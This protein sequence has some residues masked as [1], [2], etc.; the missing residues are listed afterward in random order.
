[1][2][3]PSYLAS[4]R[5]SSANRSARS[6]TD[7]PQLDGEVGPGEARRGGIV[8]EVTPDATGLRLRLKGGVTATGSLFELGSYGLSCT[9]C[10]SSCT[11][12]GRRA[13]KSMI[14]AQVGVMRM[15]T[16]CW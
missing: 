5:V 15:S 12:P 6:A 2:G 13:S 9:R 3:R 14:L 11:Y 1:M 16:I 8:F 10:I 7:L 4:M